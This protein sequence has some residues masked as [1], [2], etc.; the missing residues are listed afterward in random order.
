MIQAKLGV[1]LNERRLSQT[2][3]PS[4]LGLSALLGAVMLTGV[5]AKAFQPWTAEATP[6][7]YRTYDTGFITPPPVAPGQFDN[8][9]SPYLGDKRMKILNNGKITGM[10]LDGNSVEWSY[11]PSQ[12]RPWHVDVDQ[13]GNIDIASSFTYRVQIDNSQDG[14]AIC[15]TYGKC[16]PLFNEVDFGIQANNPA[17]PTKNIYKANF[18]DTKGDLIT[19]LKNGQTAGPIDYNDIIVEVSW[20]AGNAVGD[21]SDDYNQKVPGPLP[22]LSAP[23]AFGF[24]RKLRSNTKLL[25]KSA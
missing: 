11:K 18:D 16:A 7:T 21:I 5:E 15:A 22:I 25:R 12:I 17:L 23:L 20:G 10:T 6:L 8:Q 19:S 24:Y 14:L 1:S 2:V 3:S 9:W 13:Q 4:A